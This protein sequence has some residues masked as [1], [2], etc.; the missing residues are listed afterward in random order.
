[1][2]RSFAL[3]VLLV[4]AISASA[5]GCA[6]SNNN[7]NGTSVNGTDP[8]ALASFC[9]DYCTNRN[10]CDSK[11]GKHTCQNECENANAASFGKL[12]SDVIQ[13][14]VACYDARDCVQTLAADYTAACAKEA[15]A[16]NAPSEKAI[17]FCNAL[18]TTH[19]KCKLTSDKVACLD[20]AK[21]YG[22]PALEDASTCTT[23]A[24]TDVDTC[25]AAAL[26]ISLRATLPSSGSSS[27]SSSSS[28]SNKGN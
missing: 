24:C 27:S 22:D 10:S 3:S 9:E 4:S 7:G 14:I 17:A 13:R 6:S 20:T 23:D 5:V 25:V 8:L 26:G 1:M 11:I 15:V 12:R 16:Q 21:A 18:D 28:G 2:I 19:K